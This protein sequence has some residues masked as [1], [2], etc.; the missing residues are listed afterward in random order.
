[1]EKAKKKPWFKDTIFVILADHNGGSSGKNTLPT[2]RYKIPL[3]VYAPHIIKAQVIHKLSSQIDLMPTL[4]RI[5]NFSYKSMFYGNDILKPNFKERAFIGNYQKLG[6]LRD[7]KLT[8]LLPNKTVKEFHIKKQTLKSV[9]Y[10]DMIVD[11]KDVDDTITYYQ[12]TSFLY[13][14]NINR[15]RR[16]N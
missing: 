10:K 15:W 11:K 6:L 12:T 5:L 2:W 9:E 1:M 3:I 16:W 4:M 7:N 8:V 13:K 14:N